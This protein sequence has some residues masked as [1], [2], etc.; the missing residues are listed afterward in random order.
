VAGLARSSVFGTQLYDELADTNQFRF[1]TCDITKSESVQAAA[2]AARRDF[3]PFTVLVHNASSITIAPF[4]ETTVEHFED[5][6]RVTCLGGVNS[7]KSVLPDM[8]AAK[9]GTM[10][11]TGAT[12]A[13]RGGSSFSAFASAKFALRGLTQS[14]AREY[15]VKGIHVAHVVVDG[16]IWAQKARDRFDAKEENCLSPDAIADQ[17]LGLIE[18]DRSTWTQELDLR[19]YL[20]TF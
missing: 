1:Y 17:Y 20:E 11:F 5:L 3:G 4:I 8:L 14:L 18:Q 19:P 9:S 13:L 16:L 12:A 6:W 2:D 15:G 7:A 10:I